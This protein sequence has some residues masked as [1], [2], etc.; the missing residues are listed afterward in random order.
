M[1][2]EVAMYSRQEEEEEEER[3]RF[4]NKTDPSYRKTRHH[5]GPNFGEKSGQG[6][7][8]GNP[9]DTQSTAA[10]IY[11]MAPTSPAFPLQPV[12]HPCALAMSRSGLQS[13]PFT[14]PCSNYALQN[15]S[16]LR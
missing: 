2:R 3:E 8:A 13:R 16:P 12:R 14:N 7:G 11:H 9:G 15:R 5:K 10:P 6:T 4:K 1:E